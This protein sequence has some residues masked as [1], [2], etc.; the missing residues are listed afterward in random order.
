MHAQGLYDPANE[1]DACG[2]GFVAHIKGQKS[3]SIIEQG[4]QILK[5]IDHRGAVGADKLMGD[6]AG[7]LI[8]IP[9]QY[10]RE[11]M[12]KQGVTL[13][14]AG[15]YGVGMVFLPKENASRI[16]CEQELE[17]AVAAEG[18][19]VLGWRDVLVDKDMPMSPTVREK[20]PVI[21]QIFIGRGQD[22]I[23]TDAL[24]RKLFVIRKSAGHAIQGLNL[25]HGKEFFMPSM[26]ARTVVYKGL[27]L[28]DQVGEYYKDL[29]D[30]RCVSALAL[31]HQRFSTNTFPEWPLAHPYRLLAH[32]GE[33]NT[34][35]GNF[36][37]MR[38]REGV[39][40]SAVLGD[41]LK[42]L[43]PLIY[44]GQSDTACFD[45]ALELLVMAGYP[46][47]QAM[48]MMVPEAWENHTLMDDNRR[49]FY[50][51]HAAMMEPWD[52]PAAMAFTDG[53]HIGG[54]LDRNGLRPARYIVTD[55][56]LVVMAS[57]SGV[58]PI[59]ESKIIKK[60]RL[61]PGKMFL[62][63]LDAGRIID[64]KELKDTYANAKPYKQWIESVRIKLD[65]LSK[66]EEEAKNTTKLLDLQQAFGYTQEDLKFLMSPMAVNA[67]EATGSMGNDS[68]LAVMSNKDKTLYNYFRQLF[69]QV[70][71]PPIDP[72]REAMVMSLVS[73]IGPKPNLLDTNNINPP[74]RLEV[75]QPVLD[76]AD[77]AKLR[78]I[79]KHTGGKFKSHELNIC[80]PVAWGKDG[81][82]ARL[83]SLCAQAV[84][85]VN[86]GHNILIVSDRKV[87]ADSVAIPAL[88][89]TSAIHLHLVSKG[90]R[91]ST[92]LVV[93]TG[94][95]RETHHFALLAGYG[96]E[97][98][99]PYLAMDTLSEMAKDLPGDLAPYKAIANF[100]KA[101][102]KG[103]MKVMS[104]MGISTYMSYCGAQIFEA[105]GLNKGLVDKYFKGTASNVE[106]IGVFEVAEEAL[107]L[108][109]LAFGS[110]PV[111]ANALDAGG[112]Y[113]FRIRGEEHMWTPDAI[114]KLQH[115]A[116]ANN[117]N[118]YKEYAQIIN[119]Q[120][121]RHMTLRGLF[122]FK[123]DPAKAI[124]LDEVEPAKEIVKR[125][126]TGAMSLGSISTEAHATLAIA[127]NRI[128]G[129][130]NT[131]EGGEDSRRYRNELRGIPIKE[132]TTL[133]AVIGKDV[134]EVDMPLLAGDSLRSKIKQVASG[135]FGVT[136][137]Y[138]TSAEQI[139]IK[140]A[141]GAKPGEGGQ[142]PG[143]KV[144][145]YIAKL[146][147]SVPG[148]GLISP[149][150][151]HDIYSI[152]DLAQLIHD[153]KNVNPTADISVKLVSE[154]GVGTVATGVA[155]A[156][157]DHVV[158]AGHDGGTGASPLSSVK[159]AGS[160]W[161]LGLAETQQTLILNGLR[162]RIRV[163]ADGQ[164]KTGRDVVIAGL[165]GADEM[166]FST[167]PLVVEGCIM[168][169][170]CHLNTCPVGVATQ[171]PVLRA[172]FAG[173]PEHVVN[174]FFHI[175]EEARQI[176][177][178][179][180][181]AKFDDLIGRSDLLDKSKAISHWK[182]KGLDFSRMFYQPETRNGEARFHTEGQEHGLEKAL[183]NKLI[184][185]A[186][187]AI[188]NGEKVSFISTIKNVNR[189]VGAM[190]SG[191]VA[192]KYGHEGL[193]DDTIHI[194]LQGTAGQSAGAFLAHGITLD[195]VGEGNDYV[196]KGLSGGRIIVRPNTEFRGRAVE[197]IISG[198]TVL[199]GA[200]SGE[201]FLTGVVGERFA[202]RN[203]G[204]IA[205]VEGT[206]DHG[207]EYMTGGTVVVLGD[208]GRNFAA[209]MSGGL[210]Y[211]YDPE[212]EFPAKCNMAMVTLEKVVS[213]A[214]QESK[215]DRGSWHAT[216]RGGEGQTDEAI[217]KGLIERHFKYTGSTRARALLDDWSVARTKFVKVFPSEYK[218]ALAEMHAAKAE[219]T[220]VTAAAV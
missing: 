163:Q 175:A 39:M 109:R 203:S 99:H 41:D 72:I 161:E 137:E 33:I 159:F 171:D 3:H 5:N 76:Y 1:H 34:V 157:A 164:M 167:A 149:P 64:D 202:V 177:A 93:E 117:F 201:A 30:P 98:I 36:N 153:L 120:S 179:L 209:G 29:Q 55:D 74:M 9:D 196:G 54:T 69:A 217:L 198:N 169:R 154:V 138:L 176:M 50:E 95:A 85:A 11:E 106:G 151:H 111:L 156:K 10:Y 84:D 58:L 62:I 148:V 128:G 210:A 40:K 147:F 113:A 101:V 144:S 67:E 129:K 75:A 139:Q 215:N 135:R 21:R 184:A 220:V 173:K 37:W 180:G 188:D 51:Y 44:E 195:L 4:L 187:A 133:S 136:T 214:E 97:A 94:S 115:S 119:D 56:D 178:Q 186:K 131:G 45:N 60:W 218:R 145:E 197:N 61:Q 14:P 183:D 211:V 87:G 155:K 165:L 24:E 114:A 124:P 23:V 204:A 26:S 130:S 122:E 22:I 86:S 31:V 105:I 150:P 190:L 53:R 13:P 78:N 141:Q 170:K 158:I 199:Y 73:F 166:G 143:H 142:L 80:Y 19:V 213:A 121:K 7:I 48:M 18:Q 216:T 219:Q 100:Q 65:E 8:Q 27:L 193:P 20:E 172:K 91:T 168:M 110:D 200:V 47:A 152:E 42:K 189:T 116:R 32:N 49:A 126:A 81:I 205:V 192:K 125:F 103:L 96:A 57:E 174:Y 70:T 2:V 132:A 66:E 83:A 191:E 88:L 63:D 79:S 140:M 16:A 182:A 118:T 102:G 127:M 82:E 160:P 28:A 212:G 123:C 194:Q 90:L 43:F 134:V 59:P 208:T 6:G 162:T 181:I 46:I 77:M 185:Q 52:G 38:A 104:K 35:K 108:H 107:R 206:G 89:A 68:P 15:E 12:A 17:R 25:L 71:N 112:E 92:G 146:R 207:C